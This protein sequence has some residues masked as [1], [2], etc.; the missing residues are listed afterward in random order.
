MPLLNII[1][2]GLSVVTASSFT[3]VITVNSSIGSNFLNV[4]GNTIGFTFP[5][6]I[7]AGDAIGIVCGYIGLSTAGTCQD[8]GSNVFTNAKTGQHVGAGWTFSTFYFLNHPG[9]SPTITYTSPITNLLRA[10]VGFRVS[11]NGSII[12]ADSLIN[13]QTSPGTGANAITSGVLNVDPA[14]KSAIVSAST[15]TASGNT[16]SAGSGMTSLGN[17]WANFGLAE[18]VNIN[19]DAAATCT[20]SAG[21]GS[22]LTGALAFSTG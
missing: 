18:R 8:S 1:G 21:A 17:I 4:S 19:D 22:F 3:P 12:Y 16:L 5:S 11:A 20:T 10:I 13:P 6:A 7:V 14:K 9:G 2:S 15:N